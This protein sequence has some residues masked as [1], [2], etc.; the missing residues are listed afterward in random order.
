MAAPLEGIRVVEVANYLAAPS[1][2]ALM[3]DMG[4]DVIKV[5]PPGGDVYRAFELASLGYDH[6]F[7][8]NYA[9]E[10]DNRG[11]RSITVDLEAPGG[12]A[13]VRR[14]AAGADV[15]LTNLIQRRRERFALTIE[16]LQAANP[17]LIYAS[18][19]G[20]G[21]EGP[22]ADRAGFDYA[23]FWARSGLMSLLGDPGAPPPLCRA[24]QGDHTTALNLLAAI[25]AAL[26][27]RDQSGEGQV[28]DVTLLGTGLWTIGTDLAAALQAG[29]QPPRHDRERPPNALWNSYRCADGRW[30]LLVMLQPDRY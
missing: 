3:A 8:T 9:F 12:P 4:A 19:S 1:A 29:H 28:V 6:D 17:S 16:E 5:E 30:L 24:G 20:Y 2:G 14:L 15:F 23:A 25:L 18:F 26:R 21:T 11:K 27:L 22:D 13:L 7:A 10:L